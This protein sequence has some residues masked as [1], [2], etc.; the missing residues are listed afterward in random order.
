MEELLKN[1]E[2]V[3]HYLKSISLHINDTRK[4]EVEQKIE[5]FELLVRRIKLQQ[6]NNLV[7]NN[8]IKEV[9]N[10]L[11]KI[12]QDLDDLCENRLARLNFLNK[13]NISY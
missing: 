11:S 2:E 12:L 1:L 6:S 3:S 8:N 9:L 5:E 4:G 10:E 7:S 13:I